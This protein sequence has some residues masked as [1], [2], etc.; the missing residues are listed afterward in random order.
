M[1]FP[2][3]K[4]RWWLTTK[5]EVYRAEF[6]RNK[7]D[8]LGRG[9]WWVRPDG[10]VYTATKPKHRDDRLGR[11]DPDMHKAKDQHR[12]QKHYAKARGILFLLT[13]EQWWEVWQDSGH[14]HERGPLPHQFCMARGTAQ[15]PDIGAYEMGNIRIITNAKNRGEQ[16]TSYL[17]GNDHALGNKHTEEWKQEQSRRLQ[18][19]TNAAGHRWSEED[20]AKIGEAARKAWKLRRMKTT[21]PVD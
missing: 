19:N 18:G 20:R 17:I 5:G 7:T 4:Y 16:D 3:G 6:P 11:V 1:P 2:K 13:F 14:W 21:N 9:R 10:T 8:K 12:N 15:Q